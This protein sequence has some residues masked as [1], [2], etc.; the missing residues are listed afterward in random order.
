MKDDECIEL[1]RGSH[2]WHQ[3]SIQLDLLGDNHFEEE[4]ETETELKQFNRIDEIELVHRL[5]KRLLLFAMFGNLVKTLDNTN[6]G[7]AFI[8]GMEEELNITGLQYNWMG[9]LFMI[10]YLSQV[11]E[12]VHHV[13][14][15]FSFE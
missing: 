10:G 13:T 4:E 6:L 11:A 8:S 1:T 5:D 14:H 3:H 15:Q 2:E 7:S 12:D 9:V